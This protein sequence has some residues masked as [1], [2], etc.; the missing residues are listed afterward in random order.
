MHKRYASSY[1]FLFARSITLVHTVVNFDCF[2]PALGLLGLS[3][4]EREGGKAFGAPERGG[5]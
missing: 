3:Y 5:K 2:T 1:Y 4:P